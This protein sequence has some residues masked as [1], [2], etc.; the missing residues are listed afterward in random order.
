MILEINKQLLLE[1][2]GNVE[3]FNRLTS[4]Q[5]LPV[6]TVN[7]TNVNKNDLPTQESKQ[8]SGN[9]GLGLG[10]AGTVLGA[11]AL[12]LGIHNTM[13]TDHL[14]YRVADNNW[15]INSLNNNI[16]ALKDANSKLE[17]NDKILYNNDEILYNNDYKIKNG[18][19]DGSPRQYIRLKSPT[20]DYDRW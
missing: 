1:N 4:Q 10:I 8:T 17:Q 11:G 16:G 19:T 2:L 3:N 12:G 5:I 9:I 6:N 7:K 13:E 20:I 15:D 18:I 14:S